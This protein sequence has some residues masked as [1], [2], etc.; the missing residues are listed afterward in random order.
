MKLYPQIKRFDIPAGYNEQDYVNY[1]VTKFINTLTN[2]HS[3][4]MPRLTKVGERAY[5]LSY[6]TEYGHETPPTLNDVAGEVG[7]GEGSST[8]AQSGQQ[9]Q[10]KEAVP[11]VAGG[12][13]VP[14]GSDARPGKNR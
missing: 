3:K 10:A 9:L 6:Y 12:N 14:A 7:A 1:N 4:F 11:Q 5:E 2:I 13:K 8:P